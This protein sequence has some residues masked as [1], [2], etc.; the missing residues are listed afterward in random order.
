[1]I[2]LLVGRFLFPHSP[3]WKLVSKRLC[4]M[5]ASAVHGPGLLHCV[6][7]MAVSRVNFQM[8][9]RVMLAGCKL[10]PPLRSPVD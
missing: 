10:G 1:M 5:L 2:W 7:G 3:G 8:G 9:Q 4:H 6:E